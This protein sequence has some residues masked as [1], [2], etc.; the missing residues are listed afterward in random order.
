MGHVGTNLPANTEADRQSDICSI[1]SPLNRALIP[2]VFYPDTRANSY[3]HHC[4]PDT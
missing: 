1:E 4:R 3:A 2:A